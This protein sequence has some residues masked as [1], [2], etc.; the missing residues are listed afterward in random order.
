MTPETDPVSPDESV[1]RLVWTG[2]YDPALDFPVLPA[3]FRP[4]ADEADGISVF[5]AACV[6]APEDVLA[7]IAAE[8]RDR[9][10]I[11]LLRVA[12][13]AAL[14]LSV[15]PAPIPTVP[16]H[17]VLPELNIVLAKTDRDRCLGI[18]A[19]LARLAHD[20]IVRAPKP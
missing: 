5:R 3:A 20:R 2:F 8:K 11:V 17:A 4:R 15:H 1:I 13:L 19:D 14:E 16:G 10:G 18:Q 6:A 7:V 9:Y 12:D